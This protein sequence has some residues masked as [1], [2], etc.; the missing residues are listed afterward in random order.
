MSK[1]QNRKMFEIFK[2]LSLWK[3]TTLPSMNF[4]EH[5]D[6]IEIFEILKIKKNKIFQKWQVSR[7]RVRHTVRRVPNARLWVQGTQGRVL[8]PGY[9]SVPDCVLSNT[10]LSLL[11]QKFIFSKLNK[12][13][14]LESL[15]K[16]LLKFFHFFLLNFFKN[17]DFDFS[18]IQK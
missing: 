10:G 2:I 11:C 16:K 8:R 6:N 15:K 13:L 4:N 5:L 3:T 18:N 17:K 7:K 12:N 1:S 9:T 14:L